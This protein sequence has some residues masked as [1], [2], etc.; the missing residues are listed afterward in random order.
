MV[1][2]PAHLADFNSTQAGREKQFPLMQDRPFP[3]DEVNLMSVGDRQE[4]I[5]FAFRMANGSVKISFFAQ[6]HAH[7][8]FIFATSSK[9]LSQ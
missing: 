7:Y 9:V 1:G 6:D 8:R 4:L 2:N 5:N 3:V